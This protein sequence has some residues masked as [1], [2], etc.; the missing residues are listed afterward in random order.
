MRKKKNRLVMYPLILGAAALL[1][2]TLFVVNREYIFQEGNP[3]PIVSGMVEVSIKD[4][5]FS[6]I[7]DDPMTYLT[8]AGD[9]DGL[10]SFVEKEYDVSFQ[11]QSEGKYIFAGEGKE[12][13]LEARQYTK[14][15]RVWN[16]TAQAVDDEG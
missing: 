5:D 4:R 1:V 9:Y 6:I 14:Y 7:R 8:P 13:V 16:L 11:D 10:F 3:I 15:Y 2:L 12:I